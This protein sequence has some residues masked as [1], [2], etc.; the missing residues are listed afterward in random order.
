M[1]KK[2][3]I[4]AVFCLSISGCAREVVHVPAFNAAGPIERGYGEAALPDSGIYK[5]QFADG[6]FNGT[7]EMT[8]HNGSKYEGEFKSG[9]MHGTGKLVSPNGDFYQGQFY[10][11]YQSGSGVMMFE[12]GDS[13]EGAFKDGLFHGKGTFVDASGG[14]YTGDFQKG[15]FS[16]AGKSTAA[17]GDSFE[18]NFDNWRLSGKGVLA[19]K[20]GDRYAGGFADGLPAGRMK[21]EYQGGSRYE[22]GMEGWN[23]HGVGVLTSGNGDSFAGRYE[24][25]VA[26]GVMDVVK[27]EQD[28][29]YRGELESWQYHGKG[30]LTKSSGLKYE[31]E[32]KHGLFEG[33]GTLITPEER[34]YVGAFNYG[35]YNG[36]GTLEFRSV[37]GERKILAGN[38]RNG[39][40]AGDDAASYVRDGLAEIDAEKVMYAQPKKVADVLAKLVPQVAGQPDLYFVGFGGYGAEDVFMKEIRFSS[41]VMSKLYKVGG[42]SVSLIN[43]LKTVDEMPL[44]TVTNLEAVLNG[45][46]KQMDINEDIL[47]LYVSSHGTKEH[48]ISAS[49]DG[50]PLQDLSPKRFKEIIGATGIKWKVLVISAC[51][52]GGLIESLK[53]EYTLVMTASRADRMSFGCGAEAQLTYFGRAFF[54][55]SL[56]SQASFV[57]AFAHARDL[58]SGWEKKEK[59]EPSEPQI[60]TTPLIEKKLA[61]WHDGLARKAKKP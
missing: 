13:Y 48:E 39:K 35:S 28:E 11:G 42:R 30:V 5:G 40:Y 37:N 26:T 57:D 58:I 56:N 4:S 45:V 16:G 52:S 6:L 12:T 50:M 33:Q 10:K 3:L 61:E 17:D 53:D 32:F 31:G 20:S 19:L 1:N 8:W 29:V 60:A 25:G 9:L 15:E 55:Q 59:E 27:K 43:N 22:G 23:Y 2:I 18:G 41:S 21:V 46:A 34:K 24:H 7:G 36:E 44:A 47:F 49:L 14:T 54:E 38:W 51:Y